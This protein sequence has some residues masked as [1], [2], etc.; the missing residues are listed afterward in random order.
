MSERTQSDLKTK[1]KSE[2][3]ISAEAQLI[4]FGQPAVT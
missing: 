1:S 3:V 4:L 2:S